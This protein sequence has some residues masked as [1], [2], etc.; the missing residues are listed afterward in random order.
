APATCGNGVLDAGEACECPATDDPVLQAA[1]CKGANVIPVQQDC[2]ICRSCQI[3]TTLCPSAATTTTTTTTLYGAT[4]TTLH[5]ATTTTVPGG[6]TPTTLPGPCPGLAGIP[7]AVCLLQTG[8][9]SPLC[10]GEALPRKV[11]ARLRGKL[12]SAE[13][14]LTNA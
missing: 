4:T 13:K 6:A 9:A 3:V 10:G 5:G 7:R 11:E 1:G 14:L 2:R 12:G 8:L